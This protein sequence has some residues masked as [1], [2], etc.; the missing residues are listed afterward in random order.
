[1]MSATTTELHRH[2]GKIMDAVIHGKQTVII[3]F[4]GKDA[5]RLIPASKPGNGK[6]LVRFM[7]KMQG[8]ELP[9]R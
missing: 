8:L 6:K 9:S 1:M 5:A 7:R 2:T 3:K 4:H